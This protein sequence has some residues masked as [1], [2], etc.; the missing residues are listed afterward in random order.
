M[1]RMS[2]RV[3]I[4][5]ATREMAQAFQEFRTDPAPF[6]SRDRV[7]WRNDRL[8]CGVR[9]GLGRWLLDEL[10]TGRAFFSSVP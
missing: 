9:C 7:H 6:F 2:A 1:T 4:R 3:S 10:D 5:Q 8:E